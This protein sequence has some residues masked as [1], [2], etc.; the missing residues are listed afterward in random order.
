MDKDIKPVVKIE[1]VTPFIAILLE[2]EPDKSTM[3]EWYSSAIL[4]WELLRGSCYLMSFPT[5]LVRRKN[6]RTAGKLFV[7]AEH[8]LGGIHDGRFAV[9]VG[10]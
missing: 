8:V 1:Q 10:I 7:I 4:A 5:I 9:F 6:V 3:Q 2:Q